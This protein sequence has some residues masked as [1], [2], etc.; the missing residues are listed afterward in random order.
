MPKFLQ[1]HALAATRGDGLRPE[2]RILLEHTGEASEA[3]S[4]DAAR[5][6]HLAD[7]IVYSPLTIS[8]QDP[9]GQCG[10][11]RGCNADAASASI[12]VRRTRM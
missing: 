7:L 6:C 1:F 2:L 11:K 4:S 9:G 12:G 8:V 5:D 3:T 10:P